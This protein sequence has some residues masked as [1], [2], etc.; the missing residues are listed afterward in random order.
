MEKPQEQ[1]VWKVLGVALLILENVCPISLPEADNNAKP[2]WKIRS[3][4]KGLGFVVG[5]SGSEGSS[6]C[7]SSQFLRAP[8]FQPPASP[9][10]EARGSERRREPEAPYQ[11]PSSPTPAQVPGAGQPLLTGARK[12]CRREKGGAG[13]KQG[14]QSYPRGGKFPLTQTLGARPRPPP[15]SRETEVAAEIQG[16]KG[17]GKGA[18]MTLNARPRGRSGAPRGHLRFF[19]ERREG[20]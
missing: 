10:L 16:R 12:N 5:F 20:V 1:L 18:V 7:P 17:R 13:G 14:S 3:M 11:V 19:G 4:L 15:G 6:C 9:R 2:Y 8:R